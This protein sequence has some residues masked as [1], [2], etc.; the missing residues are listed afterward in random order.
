MVGLNIWSNTGK[1]LTLQGWL[2]NRAAPQRHVGWKGRTRAER[3]LQP[4]FPPVLLD[5]KKKN[6]HYLRRKNSHRKLREQ[7]VCDNP[8]TLCSSHSLAKKFVWKVKKLSAECPHRLKAFHNGASLR[9]FSPAFHPL[10]RKG[11][12]PRGLDF[13]QSLQCALGGSI[14]GQY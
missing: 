10:C 12:G 14:V 2:S 9:C 8:L 3:S 6:A 11:S 4:I 5:G 1:Y 7:I 13:H